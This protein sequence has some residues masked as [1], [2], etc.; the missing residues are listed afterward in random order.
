MI[1]IDKVIEIFCVAD[2]F[3]KNLE[4]ELSK[5]LKIALSKEQR[6]AREIVKG[7]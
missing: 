1:T 5:N 6:S 2:E 7:R 3:C 4:L